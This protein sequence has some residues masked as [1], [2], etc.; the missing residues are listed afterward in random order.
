[1]SRY[2]WGSLTMVAGDS[3]PFTARRKRNNRMLRLP[4]RSRRWSSLCFIPPLGATEKVII[5]AT[6]EPER[7]AQ[8]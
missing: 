8:G 1:M 7:L 5:S 2:F 3:Q 4:P 6:F